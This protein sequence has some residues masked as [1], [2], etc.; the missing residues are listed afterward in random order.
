M[1][2]ILNLADETG[3]PL[4]GG[5]NYVAFGKARLNRRKPFPY[6]KAGPSH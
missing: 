6:I 1:R 4:D 2:F 3:K 5:N